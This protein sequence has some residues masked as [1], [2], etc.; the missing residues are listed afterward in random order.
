MPRS[1]RSFQ[2]A[3]IGKAQK[4]ES[5]VD[6]GDGPLSPVMSALQPS[7]FVEQRPAKPV[8]I[9]IADIIDKSR[10]A[11]PEVRRVRDKDHVK[12]VAKQPCLLC[13]R[14]PSDAAH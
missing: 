5:A 8:G 7:P 9:S 12:S 14:K 6:I 11:H 10:L 13:G 1:I 3:A 2:C 4:L